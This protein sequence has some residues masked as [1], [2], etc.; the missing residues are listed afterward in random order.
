MSLVFPPIGDVD[1]YAENNPFMAYNHIRITDIG[2]DE[3]G[4][5]YAE[6][7]VELMPESM[8][9]HGAVHGGLIYGLADCVA[10]VAARCDGNDYVTQSAYI[11]FLRNTG[12]GAVRARAD[13]VRRGRHMAVIRVTVH[14][15]ADRLLADCTVDMMRTGA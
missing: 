3:N 8:N 4:D 2:K 9:L 15:D 14:D 1:V 13:I 7:G 10:G 5:Y 12:H 6:A 11:N